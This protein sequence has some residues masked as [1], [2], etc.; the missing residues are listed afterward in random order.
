MTPKT[1]SPNISPPKKTV[2][3]DNRTGNRTYLKHDH[4][5]PKAQKIQKQMT[6]NKNH[7]TQKHIKKKTIK[8]QITKKGELQDVLFTCGFLGAPFRCRRATI[9]ECTVEPQRRAG[10]EGLGLFGVF[11]CWGCLKCA[12]HGPIVGVL[13]SMDSCPAGAWAQS[14]VGSVWGFGSVECSFCTN[15]AERDRIARLRTGLWI[16]WTVASRIFCPDDMNW[17]F[18]ITRN[19]R[20]RRCAPVPR[21]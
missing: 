20:I 17:S 16:R 4:Q 18:P 6:K 3:P 8:T 10:F 5:K 9:S 19:M 1:I 13:L 2:P 14:L 21:S 7:P 15:A 11:G 12:G